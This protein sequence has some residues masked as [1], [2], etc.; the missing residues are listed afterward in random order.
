MDAFP[1]AEFKG[2]DFSFE[3]DQLKS[4]AGTLTLLGKAQPV[5]LT[6][7]R[8]NCYDS[9]RAKAEVCGGDFEATLTRS[10]FGMNYGLP[11]IPDDIRILIQIEAI[12]R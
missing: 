8:F 7:L 11:G 2:D 4:V 6:A 12:K 5:T 1:S 3:G 9:P 10:G